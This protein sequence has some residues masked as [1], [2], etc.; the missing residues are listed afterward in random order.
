MALETVQV[1]VFSDALVPVEVDDVVVRVFDSTGTTLI[2]EGTTGGVDPGIV[3]FSLN[4]DADGTLYQ[5]RFYISGGSIL[6]PQYIEVFSPASGS[7]TGANNFEIIATLFT[8]PTAADVNLCR[9]S[10]HVIGPTGAAKRGIDIHFIPLA[11]PMMV[12]NKVVLGE[13]IAVRTDADG[14]VSL[15]LFREGLYLA[16]VE[17]HENIQREITVPDRSSVNIGHLLFPIVSVVEYDPVGPFTVAVDDDLEV[18][19]TVITSSFVELDDVADADVE[20]TVDDEAIASVSVLSD[21]IVIT[22]V[23]PGATNLRVTRRDSSILY[24][25][26]AEISGGVV[27]IT[28]T[29]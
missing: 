21:R 15:D 18:T 14:Y 3:E 9:A 23:S 28:V 8:L 13:R 2:T 1:T 27:V 29:A 24:V 22:G 7:P 12:A 17:S 6:S 25:P 4:G 16:T 19:P 20:Y 26:D 5:L 11:A 10:G